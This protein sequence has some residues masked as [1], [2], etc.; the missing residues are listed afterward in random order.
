MTRIRAV[1]LIAAA[2]PLLA[3]CPPP[4]AAPMD[5]AP[6]VT[7]TRDVKPI[8]MAKCAPCH[9]GDHQGQHDIGNDY[10]D[11][12]MP[13]QSRD[14]PECWK[15]AAMTMP[16]TVGECSLALVMVGKMPYIA[17]CDRFPTLDAC[18]TPAQQQVIAEW[19]AAGMPE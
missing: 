15:D 8:F 16:K 11:A 10:A 19:V 9:T 4:D 14:L 13:A 6:A 18:V 1:L 5:A 7:Y 3:A 2:A 17:G 12:K